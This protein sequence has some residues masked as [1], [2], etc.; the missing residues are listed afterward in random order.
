MDKTTQI[1]ALL[2]A[3]AGT[4]RPVCDFRLME[5]VAVE[6][7]LCRARMGD[8]ELPGIRLA[9][10]G[11]GSENGLRIVPARGSIVLVADISCGT[12]RELNVI[13]YSEIESIRFHQGRTTLTADAEGAEVSVGDSR[14]RVADGL[15]RFDG[16]DNGGLVKIGELRR[17][18]ESLKSYCEKLTTAVSLGLRGVGAGTAASGEKGAGEFTAAMSGASIRIE[19]MENE[20][21]KH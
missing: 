7:D 11:G 19:Q 18:L 2:R 21:V 5:V 14:V 8:F 9:S 20:Q 10:I 12:L 16:G 3:I 4:D 15:I 1:R 6:G 13:G 17:S